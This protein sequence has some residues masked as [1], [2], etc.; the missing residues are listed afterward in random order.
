LSNENEVSGLQNESVAGY[1]TSRVALTAMMKPA[2]P[3]SGFLSGMHCEYSTS[4][5]ILSGQHTI[6]GEFRERSIELT[7]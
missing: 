6:S 5:S 2:F 3:S 4:G 1:G 7:V